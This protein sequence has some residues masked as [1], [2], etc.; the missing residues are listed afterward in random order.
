MR[1]YFVFLD[2]VSTA[3][4]GAMTDDG[5]SAAI[6]VYKSFNDEDESTYESRLSYSNID[7]APGSGV[8]FEFQMDSVKNNIRHY[9]S[10]GRAF[11]S[12]T[13][14]AS[15][16]IDVST[17]YGHGIMTFTTLRASHNWA[18]ID[19]GFNVSVAG[20]DYKYIEVA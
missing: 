3:W 11:V 6:I 14:Q 20:K 2:G 16:G 15:P 18:S 1:Q 13:G 19:F 10:G 9:A 8:T 12:L 4:N 7:A 5:N 17:K